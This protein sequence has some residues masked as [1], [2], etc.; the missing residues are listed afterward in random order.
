MTSPARP[1]AWARRLGREAIIFASIGVVSTAAYA[2]LYLAFRNVSGA[3]VANALALVV[4]AIAN[5][6]ANRRFTFGVRGGGSMV[7]DQV[8]GLIALAV[9]LA[10][11]TTFANLLAV[12]APGAG[13]PIELAVLVAANGLATVSRFVLLRSWIARDHRREPIPTTTSGHT[14]HGSLS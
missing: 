3:V 1:R 14:R 8:G 2:A 11:T 5:T 9:A 6:A 13:R 7:R 10:I 12:L 4:T